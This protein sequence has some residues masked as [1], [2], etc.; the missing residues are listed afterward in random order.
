MKTMPTDE[1]I[2]SALLT[3]STPNAAAK[4]L[5]ISINTV[6]K[7]IRD[8]AFSAELKK[9]RSEILESTVGTMQLMVSG[10]LRTLDE[11]MRDQS[12]PASVRVQAASA[13]LQNYL[14]YADYSEIERRL[15]AL[16]A[17]EGE[18]NAEEHIETD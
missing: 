4:K 15:T 2:M 3:H 9:R 17:R 18:E 14:R 10:A 7:R 6:L 1:T 11:V 8:P 5:G 12:V 13:I 16:E